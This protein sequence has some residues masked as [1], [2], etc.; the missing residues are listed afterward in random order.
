[1]VDT[2]DKAYFDLPGRFPFCSS[3]GNQYLVI[4]YHYDAN[5]ILGVAI[6]NRQA[7][8]IT[9]AWTELNK[10]FE[11]AGV[12]PNKWILDNEASQE[13]KAAI[14][15]QQAQYQLVPPYTHRANALEQAIQTFKNHFKSGIA[16]LDPDFPMSEWDRLLE[17]CFL[18]LNLL[19]GARLNPKLSAYAFLFGA[20]NF[21]ATPLVPP[22]T[23][24]IVHSK[25]EKRASWDPNGRDGWYVGPSLTHY[26]CV[27]YFIPKTR[28]EIN[29]D[30]VVFIPHQIKFPEVKLE[31]FIKQAALDIIS[32]LSQPNN[33]KSLIPTLQVG[34][35]TKNALLQ[36]ATL[37]GRTEPL[38]P[39]PSTMP[40]VKSN[41]LYTKPDPPEDKIAHMQHKPTL[42]DTLAALTRVYEYKQK[43]DMQQL[44]RYKQNSFQHRATAFLI[45]EK[46]YQHNFNK[47]FHIYDVN[48]ARATTETLLNSTTTLKMFHIY[49]HNGKKLT[50]DQV[51]Q[52]D[53]KD[54][55][56]KAT[57]NKF[58]RLAQGNKYG[59]KYRDVME[60]IHPHEVPQNK[61][62][63][64]ASF[65]LDYRPL[66]SEPWRVRMVVGGNK[67]PFEDDPGSPAASL[68]ETKILINSIISEAH[69]GAKFMS[70]DLKDY[71]LMSTM[72][73]PE[74][75]KIYKRNF[76]P[77][78]IK[79]YS[80][81][82][83]ISP[84]GYIFIRIKKGMYGLKQAALLG[85]QQLVE[86][87]KPY[88][89]EP[90]PHTDGLW[91][92]NA[93]KITFCLCVDDFGVKYFNKA[94]VDHLINALKTRYDISTD[95]EGE[96]YCGL[97]LQ[98]NYAQRY[99]DISMPKYIEKALHKFQHLKPTKPQWSPH[100]STPYIPMTKGQQQYAPTPDTTA[101]LNKH[102]TTYVQS[103]VGTLLYYGRAIDNTILPAL[104]TIASDQAKPTTTTTMRKCKRLLD[105][106]A[107]YPN[108]FICY[109]AS[110]M[111]LTIDSDAA[112][113]VQPQARSRIAGFF[114]LNLNDKT[115]TFVNGPILVECKTL[116]H[117]VASSAE[118]ETAGIFHNAQVAIPI[119]Y[120]LTQIGHT[121]PAMLLKTDNATALSFIQ[122]NITQK[123]SKSWDI[124]YYWLRDKQLQ[125]IFEF[126]WQA[127]AKNMA[128]YHTKHHPVHHHQTVR[129]QYVQD[130]P[131]DGRRSV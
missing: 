14:T 46:K 38:P 130:K 5:A 16:S 118:A 68:L 90:I 26:R 13:L 1:M 55:W 113:L 32:I 47:V 10:K 76:P 100:E 25:P 36:L 9:N 31:D 80:L 110:D 35:N 103:V 107:T 27:K 56:N 121:Q 82:N 61:K 120:I 70:L 49:N 67:L 92:H 104:N 60:F 78:I 45:K 21:N 84:T 109:H 11:D 108:V 52:G 74:Y 17:Q 85:Y 30:T 88:G 115:N 77:D 62:V 106:V 64:Y 81:Q 12:N 102:D 39:L 44:H 7:S 95:W 101:F 22:G 63:T 2:T 8:T 19:R 83:K 34:D 129:T 94:D 114:Q 96:N 4:A 105:Y 111:V 73:N 69:L 97:F 123:R 91:K 59:I 3:R 119:R 126:Y 98:W 23:R 43:K 117:V 28:A 99:V 71:F 75:M 112:Y 127:S 89:Y 51:L 50:L 18:T 41:S 116:R 87:L 48:E 40:A 57:S 20:F 53:T 15:K 42:Q 93:R 86:H 54:V 65:V 131:L 72:E 128:D 125:K 37:L 124:R 58:G 79:F 122:N 33:P 6:K 66:K 24:V 29:A